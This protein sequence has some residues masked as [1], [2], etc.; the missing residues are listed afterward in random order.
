M[1]QL[2]ALAL[3]FVCRGALA[4]DTNYQNY[5]SG[6][7]SAGLGGAFTAISSDLSGLIF[8]PAGIVD[9]R[10]NDFSLSAN[11]Y[12]FERT[13]RGGSTPTPFPD[14]T[15]LQQLTT[16]LLIIPSVAGTVRTFQKDKQ[17][18][19]YMN[20][21][22]FGV[23]VPSYREASENIQ[24]VSPGGSVD[25]KRRIRDRLFMP[26]FGY[27]RRLGERFR[28]GISNFFVLRT[29][30]AS[31]NI[32]SIAAGEAPMPY[33]I[34]DANISLLAGSLL[35][36]L[37]VKWWVSDRL[38]LGLSLSLPSLPVFSSVNIRYYRAGFDPDQTPTSELK[39]IVTQDMRATHIY[40]AVLRFGT[41]Y[42]W[43]AKLTVSGDVSLHFPV[44]YDLVSGGS[45]DVAGV[46]PVAQR[47][48]RLAVVNLNLGAEY[49]ITP[50]FS[51]SA[52]AYTDFSSSP[53]LS[54]QAFAG[55]LDQQYLSHIDLYGVTAALGFFSSNSVTRVGAMYSF[56][57]G[58]EV[59]TTESFGRLLV[60]RNQFERIDVSKSFFYVF[61]S[62]SVRFE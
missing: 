13:D 38:H 56:G 42:Y 48:T 41:A 20:G 19:G 31:E 30:D 50:K 43:R 1:R 59:V 37:G 7:R 44:T 29:L 40:P 24:Q 58:H 52:G 61:V 36:I 28:I 54:G 25:Y 34:G 23:F 21:F 53:S 51:V 46:L 15:N 12:G 39:Q 32:V 10:H 5:V 47:V 18:Q 16:E 49:L 9:D 4:S 27:A 14:P 11:L 60:D 3:L 8:N 17:A 22:A 33:R 6:G 55:V 2:A 26:G 62:S 35:W 57:R 45:V